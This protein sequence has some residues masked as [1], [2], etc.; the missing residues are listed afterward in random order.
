MHERTQCEDASLK[1]ERKK[2]QFDARDG[3]SRTGVS[4]RWSSLVFRVP[5]GARNGLRYPIETQLHGQEKVLIEGWWMT[6]GR[7][8][9]RALDGDGRMDDGQPALV[10]S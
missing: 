5:P 6:D 1:E 4:G 8:G 9:G 3:D 2:R 10:R 7:A